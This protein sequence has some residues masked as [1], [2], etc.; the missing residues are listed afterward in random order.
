MDGRAEHEVAG[1]H[2]PD[3]RLKKRLGEVLSRLAEQSISAACRGWAKTQAVYRLIDNARLTPEDQLEGHRRG[4]QLPKR[5]S[6]VHCLPHLNNTP[7]KT[8]QIR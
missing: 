3:A 7:R 4:L 5:H 1:C 6:S 8:P 2:L